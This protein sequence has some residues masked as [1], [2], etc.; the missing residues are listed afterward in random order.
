MRIRAS[1]SLV[2]RR[3]K[4]TG[5]FFL[6]WYYWTNFKISI[7]PNLNV[8]Q[9]SF[10]RFHILSDAEK[11]IPYS[12][13]F[14]Q[15]L[16]SRISWIKLIL[17]RNYFQFENHVLRFWSDKKSPENWCRTQILIC[18]WMQIFGDVQNFFFRKSDYSICLSRL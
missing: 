9:F 11:Y 15:E 12:C 14:P 16:F 7:F 18:F 10:L 1:T 3:K 4:P 2:S 13:H 17:I 6:I 8:K 5:Y